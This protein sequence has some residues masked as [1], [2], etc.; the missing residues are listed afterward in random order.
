MCKIL[1]VNRSTYYY[2]NNEQPSVNEVE[3]AMIR[4]CEENQRVY[5]AKGRSKQNFK[6]RE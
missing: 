3:Q 2:E 5:G 6:K 1:Q 4:I